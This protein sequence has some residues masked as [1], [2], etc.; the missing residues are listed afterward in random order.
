MS[1]DVNFSHIKMH[2]FQVVNAPTPPAR[3]S[4]SE[5]FRTLD[6]YNKLLQAP[7]AKVTFVF[8]N[9][10]LLAAAAAGAAAAA[11]AADADT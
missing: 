3:G 2:Q 9:N 1:R 4:V 8:I 10:I 5:M 7:G 11:A 6:I